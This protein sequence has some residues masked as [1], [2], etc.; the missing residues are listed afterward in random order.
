MIAKNIIIV[1]LVLVAVGAAI[2]GVVWYIQ[3]H[4]N[5]QTAQVSDE[6]LGTYTYECD[7][8]VQMSMTPS[9]DMKTIT[10]APLS[11][12]YPATTTLSQKRATTGVRYEGNGIILTARGEGVTL[13]E[14][15]SAISCSPTPSADNAP[16]N[17]GD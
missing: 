3:P 8:H 5:A 12:N 11:G 10:V 9:A 1:L 7:E 17:F 13:G 2:F 15:D 14:G 16:F 4:S 6:N